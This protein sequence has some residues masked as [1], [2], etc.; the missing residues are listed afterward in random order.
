MIVSARPEILTA[1]SPVG[2]ADWQSC[3]PP[4]RV[5]AR[6]AK[7]RMKVVGGIQFVVVYVEARE[8]EEKRSNQMQ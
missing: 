8:E 2:A 3:T 1:R 7:D 4:D 5:L 6:T